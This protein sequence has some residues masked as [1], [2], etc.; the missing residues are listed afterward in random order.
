MSFESEEFVAVFFWGY[1]WQKEVYVR[2]S[3]AASQIEQ[4]ANFVAV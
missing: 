2:L 4:L 1:K 3:L